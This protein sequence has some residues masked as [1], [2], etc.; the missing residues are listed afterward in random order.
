MPP[1]F[2]GKNCSQLAPEARDLLIEFTFF[3]APEICVSVDLA[4]PVKNS[5]IVVCV[6]DYD[7]RVMS[8]KLVVDFLFLTSFVL[9]FFCTW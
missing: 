7:G 3:S 8:C 4:P 1:Y 5:P 6:D 2:F 9:C